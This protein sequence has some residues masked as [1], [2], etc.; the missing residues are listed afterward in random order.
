M[1][2]EVKL[3]RRGTARRRSGALVVRELEANALSR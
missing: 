2:A 3:A 1:L